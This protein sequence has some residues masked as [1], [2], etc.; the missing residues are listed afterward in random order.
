MDLDNLR[1]RANYFRDMRNYIL[2]N[3]S[4]VLVMVDG[5]KFSSKIKKRFKLPFDEDFISIMNET[6]IYICRNISGC[7][8]AYT[9]S[10]EISFVITDFDN[11][12]TSPFYG[13]RL[14]KMQ[15]IVASLAT[16]KFNQLM[17]AYKLKCSGD[18]DIHSILNDDSNLYQ[19]DCKAWNVP[20]LNDVYEWF[21]FRQIDCVRNSKYQAARTYISHK[22]L[23][24][25]KSIEQI[26]LLKNETGIDWNEYPDGIKFGRFIYKERFNETISFINNKSGKQESIDVERAKFVAHDGVNISTEEGKQWLFGNW[27]VPDRNCSDYTIDNDMLQK[28]QPLYMD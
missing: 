16:C 2:D 6:A 4:Y 26:E 15:S 14:C 5:R 3:R 11:E 17:F 7:K 10:D 23:N 27:C 12:N 19:F 18:N 24:A 21:L 25:L 22:R 9:Q 20:T 8:F 13:N 1:K 28:Y